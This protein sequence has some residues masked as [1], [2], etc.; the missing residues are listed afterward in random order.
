MASR[1]SPVLGA[2]HLCCTAGGVAGARCFLIRAKSLS[3]AVVS[4]Y[5]PSVAGT[6]AG[7]VTH[8]IMVLRQDLAAWAT[9]SGDALA[10]DLSAAALKLL[11][12]RGWSDPQIVLEGKAVSCASMYSLCVCHHWLMAV[13]PCALCG[14]RPRCPRGRLRDC[15]AFLSLPCYAARPRAVAPLK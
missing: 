1:T 10:P 6:G 9:E 15:F 7:A 4:A 2:T 14:H 11:Q 5:E 13:F 8:S 12:G 3:E